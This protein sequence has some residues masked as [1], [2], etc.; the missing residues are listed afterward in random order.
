VEPKEYQAKTV[1]LAIEK[2][3]E[4]LNAAK[5]DLEIEVTSDG[6]RGIFGLVGGKDARILVTLKLKS[7][8]NN[9]RKD[10]VFNRSTSQELKRETPV[11]PVAPSEK[12][13]RAKEIL[14]T[15]L[16]K[17][18]M[19]VT[20][21][22]VRDD[23][24]V[25]LD[26]NGE[27]GGLLIGKNGQT[28]EALQYMVNKIVNRSPEDRKRVVLDTQGYREKRVNFLT[29]MALRLGRKAKKLRKPISTE[30]MNAYDRRIVHLTLKNDSALT[31]KSQGEGLNRKIVIYPKN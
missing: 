16:E 20:I 26:I 8:Q 4:D 9:K 3:C 29:E 7:S 18:S 6:Y 31:T 28:L 1:D 12:S 13:V 25:Q 24:I 30:P 17:M 14:E 2:A 15:I 22:V 27:G 19:P 23:E 21:K 11:T 10:L 5:E